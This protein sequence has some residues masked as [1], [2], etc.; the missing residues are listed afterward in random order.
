MHTTKL[1]AFV[2]IEGI[3]SASG[4][5][6][7]D[8]SLYI[9]GDNSV[10]LNAF[11]I[12]SKQLH[13]I[14]ILLNR[15]FSISENIVKSEKPDFEVLC[16]YQNTLYILGSGSTKRRN[17]MIE[18]NLLT[19][20][21]IEK[22]LTNAYNKLKSLANIDDSNFNIEG[23][24]FTGQFWLLFNRGSGLSNNNGVFKVDGKDL[25]KAENA[26]FIRL[27]LPNIKHSKSSFTDAILYNNEIFF[28]AT[29]EDTK[30]TYHDGAILGS[31][32]GS[33]E[34]NSLKIN[35]VTKI[36]DSQK[37]EGICFLSKS[38]DQI[39]FLLCEDRDSEE[40]SST[41]YKLTLSL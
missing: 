26:D 31:F 2:Q 9:I 6:L 3:G 30:S 5:F 1:E 24:I 13:K 34:L 7:K 17:L 4:L 8:N 38:S 10:Y 39:D 27:N 14:K 25:C 40:L 20:E 16:N 22:D 37:F 35:F 15:N 23:A 32:I 12:S 28:I 36:S 33:I 41:I 18:Y 21:V 11:N 19:E 29:S